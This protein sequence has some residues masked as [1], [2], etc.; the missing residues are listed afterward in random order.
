[1]EGASSSLPEKAIVGWMMDIVSGMLVLER[2]Q[3]VHGHLSSHSICLEERYVPLG[4]L[5][6]RFL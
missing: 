5:S 6:F 1:M 4:S 2:D 3:I